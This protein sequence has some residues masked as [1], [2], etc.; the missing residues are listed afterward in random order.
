MFTFFLL[1]S[2]SLASQGAIDIANLAFA[3]LPDEFKES[4]LHAAHVAQRF[5]ELTL[6]E[7]GDLHTTSFI[8]AAS[9][10][11][12]T[13]WVKTNSE[14]ADS[15]LLKPFS[16]LPED[17]KEK[18]RVVVRIARQ[19]YLGYLRSMFRQGAAADQ[20]VKFDAFACDLAKLAVN[21]RESKD[22]PQNA[23]IL[24]VNPKYLAAYHKEGKVSSTLASIIGGVNEHRR[25]VAEEN[26]TTIES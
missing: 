24:E 14:T 5:I 20:G 6:S 9:L 17:E 25:L 19:E 21:L 18:C 12:H 8:E 26:S 13:Q 11:Q 10:N 3:Q 22:L 1:S 7:N 15:S 23:D 16:E 2:F 4:N